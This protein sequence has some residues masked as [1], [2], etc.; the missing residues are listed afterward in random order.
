MIL[1]LFQR[2]TN[3]TRDST[4]TDPNWFTNNPTPTNPNAHLKKHKPATE[5]SCTQSHLLREYQRSCRHDRHAG[6]G[7]CR[8]KHFLNNGTD[9]DMSKLPIFNDTC[10]E[11]PMRADQG[12]RATGHHTGPTEAPCEGATPNGRTV[13]SLHT[14]W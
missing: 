4:H 11:Q 14:I 10:H 9:S 8:H 7:S 5:W 3:N 6:R 1:Y 13:P 2:R 12:F